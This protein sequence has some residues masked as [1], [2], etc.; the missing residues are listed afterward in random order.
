MQTMGSIVRVS[1]GVGRTPRSNRLHLGV[2]AD[3]LAE[4][5]SFNGVDAV[6]TDQDVIDVKAVPDD[7][8]EYPESLLPQVLK[9]LTDGPF[10]VAT[11]SQRP[12]SLSDAEHL[13]YDIGGKK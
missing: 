10:S 11:D 3:W 9:V 13:G 6:G 8:M 1:R 12:D 5:L 2:L 7:V 4:S